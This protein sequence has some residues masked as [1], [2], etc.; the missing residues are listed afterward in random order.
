M[1]TPKLDR[2][3]A[4]T[5]LTSRECAKLIGSAISALVEGEGLPP[6]DV[7]ASVRFIAVAFEKGA[8][9][10][11][12]EFPTVGINRSAIRLLSA[13]A[14]GLTGMASDEAVITALLWW[15]EVDEA[16]AHLSAPSGRNYPPETL[17]S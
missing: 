7:R 6:E 4:R 15:A 3:P 10:A 17:P 16:W 11:A 2:R 8:D 9:A 5:D 14:G 1:T 13:T 12:A